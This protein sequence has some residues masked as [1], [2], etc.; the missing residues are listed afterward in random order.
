M[1][2]FL[3]LTS[4]A[5][6]LSQR[7]AVA[8]DEKCP[9]GTA[10]SDHPLPC[11]AGEEPVESPLGSKCWKCVSSLE[12]CP[13]DYTEKNGICCPIGW[14]FPPPSASCHDDQTLDQDS[15]GCW[16][17]SPCKAPF[18][19]SSGHCCP[20]GQEVS[21]HFGELYY[22]YA[23]SVICAAFPAPIWPLS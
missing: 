1:K 17:C 7:F 11:N 2:L 3:T 13:K 8:S 5:I 23:A 22:P 21:Y 9:P 16:K 14:E 10:K 12:S 15:N 4:V 19:V 18:H 6:I 20:D